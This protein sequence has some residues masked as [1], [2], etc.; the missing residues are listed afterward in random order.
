M[1]GMKKEQSRRKRRGFVL[2]LTVA[3]VVLLTVMGLSLQRLGSGARMQAVWATTQIT[4]TAAADAG[5]TKAIY[6]MNKNLNVKP[7]NFGNVTDAVDV[8]LT[9]ANADYT[10]TIE[11]IVED[12]EYRITSIGQSGWAAKTVSAAVKVQGGFDYP[13]YAQ[14]YS[15]PK[16]PKPPKQNPPAPKP[17]K[18]GGKIELK[19]YNLDSYSSD[20]SQAYSGPIQIRTNNNHKKSVKLRED[21]VINGDVVVGP[22]GDPNK[23]I[24]MKDRASIT[25]DAYAAI[26]RKELLSVTVPSELESLPAIEYEWHGG[27]GGNVAITGNVKYSSFIIPKPHTQDI[28]GDCMIYVTGDMKVED[29]ANLTLTA[30]S[31]LKLYVNGRLEVKKKSKGLINENQDPTKLLIYGMDDCRKVKIENEGAGDFYGAVYAPFAKV[32]MKTDG[33]L[34]GAFVGWDVKLKKKKGSEHGTFYF[35][36]S[37]RIDHLLATDDL[38]M[39]FVVKGWREE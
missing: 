4:A 12:S 39:R 9:N 37:L 32:E 28:V 7:W 21:V 35:D 19:G 16:Q 1:I 27:S 13:I 3:M 34:Y 5:F 33:D 2:P 38:A 29:M 18:K 10:Y 23:V 30:G 31:S 6:E 22:S 36:R 25:G 20:P 26:E 15:L 17:L 11:E 14:G 24:E 8:A